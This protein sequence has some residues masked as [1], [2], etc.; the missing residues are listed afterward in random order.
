MMREQTDF[1]I[2][3]PHSP[4]YHRIGWF[5][6]NGWRGIGPTE[7]RDRAGKRAGKRDGYFP[8]W[9]VLACNSPRCGGRALVPVSVLTDHAD[10]R[11][12]DVHR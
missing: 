3:V 2:T 5:F 12:P 7:R 9:F 6:P 11:D 1:K 10:Q 8:E 4:D